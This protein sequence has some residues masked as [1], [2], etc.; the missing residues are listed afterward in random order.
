MSL[1]LTATFED[2]DL[3]G[4]SHTVEMK[5]GMTTEGVRPVAVTVVPS[6][7]GQPVTGTALRAV[8]VQ[9]LARHAILRAATRGRTET[10]EDGGTSTEIMSPE[11]TDQEVELIRLRGPVRESLEVAAWLYNVACVIGVPPAKEVERGLGL[12]RTTATKWIKR[13]R[14]MGLIESPAEGG[15]DGQHQEAT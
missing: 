5:L 7:E 12:P 8:R 14:D 9:E 3:G 4:S 15:T 13:A 10:T 11:L 1:P 6:A 2:V